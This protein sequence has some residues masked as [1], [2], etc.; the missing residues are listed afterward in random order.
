MTQN[1]HI[2]FPHS[3]IVKILGLLPMLYTVSELAATLHIP[4][5]T[6]RTWLDAGAPSERDAHGRIWIN[7][8]H[9][10]AWV[11]ERRKRPH[12]QYVHQRLLE[13]Q[14]FCLRCHRGV[15]L[16][17]PTVSYN[18]GHVKILSAPCPICGAV[19]NRGYRNDR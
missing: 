14:A 3:V 2:K 6:L 19:V 13:N 9:F 8:H 5:S 10:A 4:P 15:D 7:G 18:M 16:I 11:S 12:P 17:D 1:L